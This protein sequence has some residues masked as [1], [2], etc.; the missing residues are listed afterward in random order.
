MC[1]S[2]RGQY[3]FKDFNPYFIAYNKTIAIHIEATN[4]IITLKKLPKLYGSP[5]YKLI[6]KDFLKKF[7][8]RLI[9]YLL[10]L[11]QATL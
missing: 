11:Q 7:E 2:Y 5:F 10:H 3:S 1:F 6:Y 4:K 9:T 8:M